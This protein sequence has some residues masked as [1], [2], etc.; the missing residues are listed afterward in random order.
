MI[1]EAL[2][3]NAQN[4]TLVALWDGSKTESLGGT[5]HLRA[6]AQEYG[7]ALVTIYTTDLLKT[8]PVSE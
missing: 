3:L 1:H 4:L 7:A 6:V 8:D 2:A 5:Y